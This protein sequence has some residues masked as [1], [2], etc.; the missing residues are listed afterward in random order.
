MDLIPSYTR[1]PSHRGQSGIK[2]PGKSRRLS[3][4]VSVVLT[5]GRSTGIPQRVVK[6]EGDEEKH[7][8]DPGWVV[9]VYVVIYFY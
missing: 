8:V 2:L 7:G 1:A 5:K 6:E 3:H 9:L 4:Q